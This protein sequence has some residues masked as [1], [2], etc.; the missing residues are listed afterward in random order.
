M[1]GTRLGNDHDAH[2]RHAVHLHVALDVGGSQFG[3][4]DV[5]EADDAV[6]VFLDDEVVELF[7]CVHQ[8]QGADG[9][10][11]SVAFDAAR[12]ELDVLAV[13]GILDIDGRDAVARH[14]G[15]VE[16]Q[17]HGVF[18]FTPDADAAHVGDGLKLFLHG[19]VGYL[20]Q[21]EQGAFVALQGY[22]QDGDGVGIGFRYGGRVAVAG[23]VALGAR[24]LVAYVVGGSL[25]VDGQFKFDGDAT[26]SLLA[27]TGQRADAG[28]AVDVLLQRFGNLVFD[29]VG[30]G[31]CVRARHGDDGIVHRR[32]FAH[33]EVGITDEA[34]KQD[35][36]GQYR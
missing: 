6:G 5:A 17:A 13:D 9:Q 21:F 27:H 15:R 36:E 11:G 35:D 34:E 4:S 26:L 23:Q 7:G 18:L 31:S 32:I 22:H 19:E 8:A 24:H 3:T 16:P 10:F 1:V 25:Q 28:D 12:G 2:H 33:A 20:A 29:D 14:F 30:V